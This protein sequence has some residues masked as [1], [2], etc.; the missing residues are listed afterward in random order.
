MSSLTYDAAL[1]QVCRTVA[2]L[3]ERDAGSLSARTRLMEDLPCESIDLLEISVRLGAALKL[4]MDDDALFLQS[5]RYHAARGPEALAA[6]YPHLDA[7]RRAELLCWAASGDSPSP[8]TLG[9]LASCLV[10]AA[11]QQTV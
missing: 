6:A 2:D 11:A 9:D 7:E 8:L 5:L 3:F 10:H 4:P 1:A